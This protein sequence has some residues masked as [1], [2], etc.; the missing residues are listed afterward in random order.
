MALFTMLCRKARTLSSREGLEFE[1]V[2]G[3]KEGGIWKY[4]V[5]RGISLVMQEA[6]SRQGQKLMGSQ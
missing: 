3:G 4:G 6:Y 5:A 1:L 2:Q